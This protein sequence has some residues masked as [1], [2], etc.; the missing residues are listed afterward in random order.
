MP[1]HILASVPTL[2][3]REGCKVVVRHTMHA[4]LMCKLIS[5]L[6]VTVKVYKA[7]DVIYVSSSYGMFI[8]ILY[9]V[10]F[11]VNGKVRQTSSSGLT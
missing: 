10:H 7:V 5:P 6:G 1:L 2:V 8:S 9:D 3:R 4:V 11:D